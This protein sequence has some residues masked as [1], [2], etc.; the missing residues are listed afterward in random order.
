MNPDEVV[1]PDATTGSCPSASFCASDMR[2]AYYGGTASPA[3]TNCRTVRYEGTDLSDLALYY[4]TRAKLN[5]SRRRSY[6]WTEFYHFQQRHRTNSGHGAGDGNGPGL[7]M[8]YNYVGS[9]DTAI[10]S[11]MVANTVAPISKQIGCSWADGK[12]SARSIRTSSRWGLRTRT[13]LRPRRLGLLARHGQFSAMAGGRCLCRWRGGTDLTILARQGLGH[14]K[15]GWTDSGGG[16]TTNS[17]RSRLAATTGVINSSTPDL[18]PCAT[19]RTSRRTR[20]LRSTSAVAGAALR[21]K[22][23]APVL[24]RPCGPAIWLLPISKQRPR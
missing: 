10:L 7:T 9:T 18:P 6:P 3:W 5:L 17:F 16:I 22:K 11:A 19:A 12:T 13:S 1:K 8:V 21:T 15:A 14:R 20:I 23:V 24:P 4:I 2:A